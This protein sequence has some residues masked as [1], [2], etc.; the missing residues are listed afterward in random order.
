M[1]HSFEE[2]V[3]TDPPHSLRPAQEVVDDSICKEAAIETRQGCMG[4]TDTRDTAAFLAVPF[5]V[6]QLEGKLISFYLTTNLM[7][8]EREWKNKLQKEKKVKISQSLS[9]T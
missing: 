6:L 1:S 2:R 3:K 4:T 5:L 8:R 7:R 9:Q